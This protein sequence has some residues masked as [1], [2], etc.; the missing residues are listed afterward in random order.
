MFDFLTALVIIGCIFG[1]VY[2]LFFDEEG[3]TSIQ[4]RLSE[5]KGTK[6]GLD[7]KSVGAE[8]GPAGRSA[9]QIYEALSKREKAKKLNVIEMLKDQ[10]EYKIP[11]LGL[12]LGKLKYT[13]KIKDL[14]K[15]ADVKMPIDLFFMIL[16][17][18]VLPFVAI[19]LLKNNIFILIMGGFAGAIPF[20]VLHMKFQQRLKTFGQHFPDSLGV[21]S[22]SLRAGHS[23]LSSF[24][25]V[26]SE[27]PYP[28]NKLFKTVSDE[29][30]LGKEVRDALEDMTNHMPGSEDLKFFVTAV[31]IQKEIGGNL[32]EILDTLNFTIR[33]REK[34]HGLIK[35]QTAQ[36]QLSGIVLGLAPVAIAVMVTMMNPAYME[37]LFETTI[38]NIALFG[39][40]MMSF[41]GFMIIQK[42]TKIRV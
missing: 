27:S 9:D 4:K 2:L 38:G 31:L 8:D 40:F 10:S 26:A 5:I 19:A 30:S 23:L 25:M 3:D 22:N 34:I 6:V 13:Q 17:I 12:L 37:P 24:Q 11:L 20:L 16:N 15:K 32:A 39:S 36:A 18:C 7:T 33:E 14:M 1:A 35:T 28:V 29:I 42:I 21:I 41:T